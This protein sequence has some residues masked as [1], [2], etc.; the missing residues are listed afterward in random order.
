MEEV[1]TSIEV[2]ALCEAQTPLSSVP[3][4]RQTSE[5]LMIII[6]GTIRRHIQVIHRT[7]RLVQ[8]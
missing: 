7:L 3:A 1:R 6:A 5:K 4:T 2:Q 8:L